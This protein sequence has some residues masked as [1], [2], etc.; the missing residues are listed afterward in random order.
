[1]RAR[2]S[3]LSMSEI[4]TIYV[5][6]D[7][8]LAALKKE[9]RKRLMTGGVVIRLAAALNGDE[10]ERIRGV[11]APHAEP[12]NLATQVMLELLKHP[13]LSEASRA[14]ISS[15]PLDEVQAAR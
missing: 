12:F 5:T 4:H 15:M 7:T 13:S 1:M 10:C 11:F 3:D 8:D 2:L 14:A 9:A 6:P